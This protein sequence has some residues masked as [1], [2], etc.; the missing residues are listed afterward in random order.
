MV[1]I[2]H[3]IIILFVENLYNLLK[4]YFNNKILSLTIKKLKISQ[5]YVLGLSRKN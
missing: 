5:A 2:Y 3:D 4:T 1:I